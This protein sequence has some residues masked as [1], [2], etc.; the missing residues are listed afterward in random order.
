MHSELEGGA[1]GG[2]NRTNLS[3]LKHRKEEV[4]GA[5]DV[6]EIGGLEEPTRPAEVF[7]NPET[8]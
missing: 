5:R 7:S 8:G 6:P 2:V 4:W 1:S 3:I